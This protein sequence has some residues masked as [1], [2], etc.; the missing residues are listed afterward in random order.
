MREILVA[1]RCKRIEWIKITLSSWTYSNSMA[2]EL[3]EHSHSQ[4]GCSFQAKYAFWLHSALHKICIQLGNR[5]RS[6]T[7]FVSVFV[8]TL[9]CEKLDNLF[10]IW[11][12]ATRKLKKTT[13]PPA[14]GTNDLCARANF[15]QRSSLRLIEFS[16]NKTICLFI[17]NEIFWIL[18]IVCASEEI[19]LGQEST[20][21]S[22]HTELPHAG[23]RAEVHRM[24]SLV[25]WCLRKTVKKIYT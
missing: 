3:N 24:Q 12:T 10:L 20:R 14:K 22:V 13:A 8:Q 5:E 21:C 18:E 25:K 2:M 17:S 4:S 1:L 23:A 15:W 6:G 19:G 16:L 7:Q 9:V 11:P